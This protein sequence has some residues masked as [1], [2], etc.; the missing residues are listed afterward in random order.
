VCIKLAGLQSIDWNFFNNAKLA[1][2]C[3]EK[4]M[5]HSG[6]ALA[7]CK[8]REASSIK[9]FCVGILKVRQLSYSVWHVS[10]A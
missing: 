9:F 10:C 3:A 1:T 4:S 6:T 5:R 7:E 8:M 2:A